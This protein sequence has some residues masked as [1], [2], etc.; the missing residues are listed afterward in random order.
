[1][2]DC[3]HAE[4]LVDDPL[5]DEESLEALIV[6]QETVAGLLLSLSEMP[7]ESSGLVRLAC[8]YKMPVSTIAFLWGVPERTLRDRL[9]KAKT[10][11]R[12]AVE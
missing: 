2:R 1:M 9:K 7:P 10:Y 8:L 11:L 3:R 12:D 4:E 5:S 6:Q